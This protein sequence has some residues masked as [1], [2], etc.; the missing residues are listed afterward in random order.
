MN[1]RDFI[2]IA[3]ILLLGYA[4]YYLLNNKDPQ[5]EILQ[6]ENKR[7]RSDIIGLN[8]FIADRDGMIEKLSN[9]IKIDSF[10]IDSLKT[11]E[12]EILVISY[13]TFPVT[14]RN[15]AIDSLA[16]Q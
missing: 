6:K 7:L 13:R 2:Y 5:V 4:T 8:I 11:I 1:K 15:R 14:D 9:E 12:N 10:K 3:V 16:S